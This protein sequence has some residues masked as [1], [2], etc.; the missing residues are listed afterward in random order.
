[1]TL[2]IDIAF[3]VMTLIIRMTFV[4][5][6]RKIQTSP[7]LKFPLNHH[8]VVDPFNGF[9]ASIGWCCLLYLPAIL[10]SVSLISL[11]RKVTLMMMMM[12]M[13]IIAKKRLL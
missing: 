10:L 1:M 5:F 4:V 11:Y 8:Q 2:L 13:M 3:F 6:M 12:M 9:W 7:T